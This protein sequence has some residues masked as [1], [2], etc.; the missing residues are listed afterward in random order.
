MRTGRWE[1]ELGHTKKSGTQLTVAS[2]WSL[3]RDAQ[4]MPTAVLITN[5]DIT[6]RK[7]AEQAREEIEEQWRAAFESN[8]TMYFIVD[9]EGKI[10]LVNAFGAEKLGYN[11]HE[12][13][14]QPVLNVFYEPDRD[15]VQ[16]HALECFAQPG[17]MM[18]WE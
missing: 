2:R 15:A 10:V 1:G 13:I 17:G 6:D 18:R 4:G 9:T 7:R 8:P 12:L 14:G 16:K 3:E 11:V 5:T